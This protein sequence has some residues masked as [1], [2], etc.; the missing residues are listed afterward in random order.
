MFIYISLLF[1]AFVLLYI[2]TGK[3]TR[4][5]K[6]TKLLNAPFS[7]E[8][9]K[10]LEKNIFFYRHLPQHFKKE[11]KGDIQIFLNEKRFKGCG[12]LKITDEIRL[13]I[14]AEACIL[15]LNRKSKYYPHLS[16]IFVYPHIYVGGENRLSSTGIPI[17]NKS[18]RAG[19]SWHR[20][21][22]VLAWDDVKN[23]S[24]QNTKGH[25]VVLHEFAHQLDQ[26]DGEADGAPILPK[27][28]RYA[29][30]TRVFKKEYNHL[31]DD[32]K[33]QR[34]N[35]LDYYGGTNPAEFFAVAT[36]TF[37]TKPQELNRDEPEL[38][39]ELKTY[40]ALDPLKWID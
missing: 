23:S 10:I 15:L 2:L 37:F 19:E 32:V 26:E 31:L 9:E 4:L 29:E 34:K 30:W 38:Y 5:I 36:E 18:A 3:L 14:A 1:A 13:T 7:F 17:E 25:N 33:F 24:N 35:V 16:T 8:W 6:R 12:G 39:Q 27:T 28:M 20:G 11:L 40:Y 21:P 22:L